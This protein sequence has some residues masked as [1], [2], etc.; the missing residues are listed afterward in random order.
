M[1]SIWMFGKVKSLNKPKGSKRDSVI[2]SDEQEDLLK[3][4]NRVDS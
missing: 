4:I 3:P 1:A 2:F